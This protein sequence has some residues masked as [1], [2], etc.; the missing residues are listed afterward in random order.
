MQCGYVA[1]DY[2]RAGERQWLASVVGVR[3]RLMFEGLPPGAVLSGFGDEGSLLQALDRA[4]GDGD[5]HQAVHLSQGAAR[6][7]ATMVQ[8]GSCDRAV[9]RQVNVSPGGVPKLPINEAA[10]AWRGI[11]GDAHREPKHHG[12][13]WQALCLWSVEVIEA[14]RQEGHPIDMGYAGE[15]LTIAGLD[16]E[17]VRTGVRIEIGDVVAEVTVPSVPCRKNAAWFLGGKFTRM[18][19]SLHPGWSRWY[20]CVLRPGTVR[21]GDEVRALSNAPPVTA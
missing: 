17:R 13:A 15:N 1:E 18:S 5:L 16:W 19:H 9:L 10:I 20:A 4:V 14:L 12:H 3:V 11:I 7:S 6:V 21:P 8:P 2:R